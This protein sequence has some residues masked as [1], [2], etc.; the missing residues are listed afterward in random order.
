MK[1]FLEKWVFTAMGD[2][3]SKVMESWRHRFDMIHACIRMLAK[4]GH[5]LRP[6]VLTFSALSLGSA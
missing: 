1:G 3:A 4:E 5:G 2:P 6:E